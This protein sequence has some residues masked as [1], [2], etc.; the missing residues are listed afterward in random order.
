[1][2]NLPKQP[3]RINNEKQSVERVGW[4]CDALT[5]ADTWMTDI[6]LN[7]KARMRVEQ[8]SLSK[9][10]AWVTLLILDV[11]D[12]HH[13]GSPQHTGGGGAGRGSG[14]LCFILCVSGWSGLRARFT[15]DAALNSHSDDEC[16]L[17]PAGS[18]G[19]Q[20][21]SLPAADLHRQRSADVKLLGGT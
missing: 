5:T 15:Q 10:S 20:C 17:A 9:L 19:V 1:M 12:H 3:L 11:T 16:R 13:H 18:V 2:E 8:T 21:G 14:L 4:I 7:Q 6:I